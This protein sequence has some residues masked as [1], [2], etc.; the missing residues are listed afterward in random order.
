MDV[1]CYCRLD[2]RQL[3]FRKTQPRL[4]DVTIEDFD[5]AFLPDG[6]ISVGW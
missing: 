6:L 1:D 4:L 2:L 3:V 5:L